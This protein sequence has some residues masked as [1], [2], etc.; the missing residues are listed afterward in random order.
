MFKYILPIIVLIL[1]SGCK[2]SPFLTDKMLIHDSLPP[3]TA[4]LWYQH[5]NPLSYPDQ[6]DLEINVFPDTVRGLNIFNQG[7][8]VLHLPDEHP[9]LRTYMWEDPGSVNRPDPSVPYLLFYPYGSNTIYHSTARSGYTKILYIQNN[10]TIRGT[11][12]G[13]LYNGLDSL[14]IREGVFRTEH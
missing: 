8:L 1:M 2:R 5:T 11:F 6:L 14:Y 13:Y 3:N 4:R 9:S 12:Q 10:W 7:L